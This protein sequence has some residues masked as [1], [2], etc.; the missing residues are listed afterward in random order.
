MKPITY[1]Y[2]GTTFED[3]IALANFWDIKMIPITIPNGGTGLDCTDYL[4]G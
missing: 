4:L 1:P 3:W 2:C